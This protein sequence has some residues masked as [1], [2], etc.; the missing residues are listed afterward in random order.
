[1][2]AAPL[3]PTAETF[4]EIERR[5]RAAKRVLIGTHLNPDGD[6]LGSA[7]G[8]MHILDSMGVAS[9]VVCH[10]D[11][12]YMLRFLPGIERLRL[13]TAYGDHDLAVM[14]D[15]EAMERLGRLR[16]LFE[17]F[18]P[19]IVIDH[20]IPHQ[21]PGTIRLIDVEAPATALILARFV[22]H[23]GLP[24]SPELA[25]C[26]LAGIVTDTGS[27]RFGN[28]TPEALEVSAELLAAGGDIVKV[29]EEVYQ[30]H[31]Y[32]AMKLLG[33]A[34]ERTTL[35]LDGRLAWTILRPEDF[36][37]VG[38]DE[39]HTEGIVSELRSIDTVQVAV[40][41]KEV[42]RG[43]VRVNLRS[44]GG[45]DVAAVARHFGGGGHRSAAG[46]TFDTS[47]DKAAEALLEWLR[48]CMAS[49]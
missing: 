16:P 25:T 15:L 30:K 41:I 3:G 43:K 11:A 21:S 49:S 10:D 48:K 12:P 1:M 46:C 39:S 38:A 8:L 34:L 5:L 47:V 42:K 17:G 33:L 36:A 18:E 22:K 20:H 6:A 35:E 44:R 24:I 29:G 27:F 9:E 13:E 37:A 31:P 32:P 26:L 23:I 28:T 7:L 40:L 45:I 2:S 4:D 19:L 14:L